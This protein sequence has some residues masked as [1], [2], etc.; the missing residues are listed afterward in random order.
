MSKKKK[1]AVA[2]GVLALI[3]VGL[4]ATTAKADDDERPD[5]DDDDDNGGFKPHPA[6]PG[7]TGCPPGQIW[8]EALGECVD[9]F[10]VTPAEPGEDPTVIVNRYL[11]PGDRTGS[12]YR[13]KSG[14]N[15][16]KVAKRALRGEFGDD[17]TAATVHYI[18]RMAIHSWNLALYSK[19]WR[20]EEADKPPYP[21]QKGYVQH[22]R[23]TIRRRYT[24]EEYDDNA[25]LHNWYIGDA[26]YPKHAN[27]LT[28]LRGGED[29]IRVTSTYGNPV[30][31]GSSYGLIWLP[32]VIEIVGYDV[33]LDP[34]L[35]ADL[36][37]LAP[38]IYG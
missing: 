33:N 30:V 15:P 13:I 10:K 19:I 37:S 25:K 28:R 21:S 27:N 38:N 16:T 1:A 32:K 2:I 3:G 22:P 18:A 24:S 4:W 6:V 11:G 23:K 20:P 26:Y 29:P 8:S 7:D 12:L 5:D 14:D 17:A 9:P 36:A 35:P 31:S 34:G